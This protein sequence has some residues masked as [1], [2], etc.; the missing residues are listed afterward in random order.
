MS[1]PVEAVLDFLHHLHSQGVSYSALNTARSALSCLEL[2]RKGQ[3]V[4]CHPLVLRFMKSAYDKRPTQPH[5]T[6]IWD[7]SVVLEYLKLLIPIHTLSLKELSFKCV[8]LIALTT[9]SRVQSIQQLDLENMS[10]TGSAY[11]F[12]QT[13][14][15]KQSRAGF[16]NPVVVLASYPRDNRVCIYS[17]ISEYIQRTKSLRG[18]ASQLF[19]SFCKPYMPVTRS[20]I[21]RWLRS[22]LQMSGIDIARFSSHSTRAA[23]TS[24]AKSMFCPMDQILATGGWSRDCQTFANHYDRPLAG[25]AQMQDFFLG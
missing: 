1:L 16:P 12:R 6:E 4:G 2:E 23:A 7:L 18:S 11:H 9:A 21:S 14:T 8:M 24:K 13:A 22:V 25:G 3:T 17:Y 10:D 19:I 5:H 15:I 20:T